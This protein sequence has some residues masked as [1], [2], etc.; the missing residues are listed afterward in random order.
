MDAGKYI[1]ILGG[2]DEEYPSDL[3]EVHPVQPS[4]NFCVKLQSAQIGDSTLDLDATKCEQSWV[5]A[6]AIES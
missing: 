6:R 2:I 3:Q 5:L 4:P 1:R